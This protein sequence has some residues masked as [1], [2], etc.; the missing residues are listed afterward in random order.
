VTKN[1]HCPHS[2]TTLSIWAYFATLSITT[3]CH[4]AE[5]HCVECHYAEYSNAECQYGECRYGECR[6]GECR[7]TECRSTIR[8][9][10]KL[11]S[12]CGSLFFYGRKLHSLKCS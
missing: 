5:C 8:I 7:Y 12:N 6:Y 4:Y 9:V 2:T 3:L 11:P 10:W 1:G